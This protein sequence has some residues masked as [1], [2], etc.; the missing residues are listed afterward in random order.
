MLNIVAG[1]THMVI[2]SLNLQQAGKRVFAFN[3]FTLLALSGN[4][5]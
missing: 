1:W 3:Y 2:V 4:M 5:V